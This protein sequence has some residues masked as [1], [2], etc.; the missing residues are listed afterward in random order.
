M[1]TVVQMWS[2]LELPCKD[3]C[4]ECLKRKMHHVAEKFGI[5]N[6]QN[7]F[8]TIAGRQHVTQSRV[9]SDYVKGEVDE[10]SIWEADPKCQFANEAPL[11]K[12][13]VARPKQSRI[14]HNRLR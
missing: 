13:D 6:V 4:P 10:F 8:A 14:L 12:L 9:E 3:D 7:C 2:H 11:I 1:G 5:N